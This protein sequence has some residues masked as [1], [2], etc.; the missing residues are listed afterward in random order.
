MRNASEDKLV[1]EQGQRSAII[2]ARFA[3][4]QKAQQAEQEKQSAGKIQIGK[5]FLAENKTKEGVTELPSG[6]Q[7]KVLK[8]STGGVSPTATDKVKV[9]YEGRL[10]NGT[11]FDSSYDRG[12]PATFGVGQ[13]ISGWTE[14]LQIMKPGDKWEVYIPYNLA[15]GERGAGANIGPYETLI[16]TVELLEIVK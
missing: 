9:D 5:D 6:L 3:E 11:V 15:Y 2:Q 10:I 8:P 13:V 12:T 14:I 7:Y 16:F 4:L 1:I